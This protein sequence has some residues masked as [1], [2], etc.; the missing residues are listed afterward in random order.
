M[1]RNVLII[2]EVRDGTITRETLEATAAAGQIAGGG[3]VSGMLIGE[4]AHCTAEDWM[5]YGVDPIVTLDNGTENPDRFIGAVLPVVMRENPDLVI[6]GHAALGEELPVRLAEI[7]DL[8]LVAEVIGLT[9]YQGSLILHQEENWHTLY[10]EE[11][12]KLIATIR[13]GR[14]RV[15]VQDRSDPGLI[16]PAGAK[17]MKIHQPV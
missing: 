5:L 16:K 3:A 11:E 2:G 13:P 9:R 7:L 10:G 4:F 8:P 15:P 14:F 12:E 6:A 17:D 1:A